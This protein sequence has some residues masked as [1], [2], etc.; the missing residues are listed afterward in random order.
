[1]AVDIRT[2]AYLRSDSAITV[3]IRKKYWGWDVNRKMTLVNPSD[4]IRTTCVGGRC[5]E[6]DPDWLTSRVRAKGPINQRKSA[7]EWKW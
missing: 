1:M 4:I 6:L 2:R 7:D 3:G 5:G